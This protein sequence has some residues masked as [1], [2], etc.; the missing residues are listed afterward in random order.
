MATR[1]LN[2]RPDPTNNQSPVIRR[3]FKPLD[4]P[5]TVLE[6]LQGIEIV[7]EG[8]VGKNVMT[9]PNQCAFWRGCLTGAAQHKFI[10]FGQEFGT[11]TLANLLQVKQCHATHFAPR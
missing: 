9:G 1:D 7:K 4:D 3:H 10:Q 8:C 5:P 2:M 6:L 11:V